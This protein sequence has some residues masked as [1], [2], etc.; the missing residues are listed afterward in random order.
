MERARIKRMW[1]VYLLE[2]RGR[3]LYTGITNDLARRFK[4]HQRATTRYTSYNPPVRITYT[5]RLATKS[6]A[7]KREAQIKRWPRAKKLALIDMATAAA[8]PA[9]ML[10]TSCTSFGSMRSAASSPS[11]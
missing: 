8:E 9:R 10:A 4:E 11:A 6:A 7:L 3:S 2:C 1:Y 5:E